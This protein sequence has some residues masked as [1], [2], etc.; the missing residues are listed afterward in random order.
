[1]LLGLFAGATIR[2]SI[3][4]YDASSEARAGGHRM[5]RGSNHSR[6]HYYLVLKGRARRG[7]WFFDRFGVLEEDKSPRRAGVRNQV[8]R[9][10]GG[11]KAAHSMSCCRRWKGLGW[12]LE[13][14]R[15][16]PTR[17]AYSSAG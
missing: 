1:M 10:V 13:A 16:L 4:R 12:G 7:A 15:R 3:R 11:R 8:A 17:W 14:D 5:D 9:R 2:R 6:P